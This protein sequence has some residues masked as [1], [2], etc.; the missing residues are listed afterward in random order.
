MNQNEPDVRM[1]NVSENKRIM[2]LVDNFTRLINATTALTP[3]VPW[4]LTL[5]LEIVAAEN[6]LNNVRPEH[7]DDYLNGMGA[8]VRSIIEQM[9]MSGAAEGRPN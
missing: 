4:E 3:I 6:I 1:V 2:G 7:V 5:A 8:A 9:R